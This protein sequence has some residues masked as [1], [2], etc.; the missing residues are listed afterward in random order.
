MSVWWEMRRLRLAMGFHRGSA[1]SPMCFD[2]YSELMIL[3]EEGLFLAMYA[4]DLVVIAEDVLK[5][6]GV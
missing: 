4:D 6:K 5:P 1:L 3:K 2:I